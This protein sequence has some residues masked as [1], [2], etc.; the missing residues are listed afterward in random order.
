MEDR[1]HALIAIAFLVVFGVGAALI[2]LWMLSPGVVR[3]PYLLESKTSV[4]GL[5]P[6]SSVKFKGVLVGK[7]KTIHLDRRTH[8]S[9]E[10]MIAV[11]KNFPLPKGTY[12]TVSSNG[13]IG[14]E[15]VDLQLGPDSTTIQTSAAHPAH[16][17]LKAGG[18]S[19][20]MD[21][22]KQIV[23]DVQETLKSAQAVLSPQNRQQ[24][25]D[26]LGNLNKASA[27]LVQLEKTI[28]PSTKELPGLLAQA[29]ETLVTARDM[30]ANANTLVVKAQQP[31]DSLGQAASSTAAFTT[32]LSQETTPQLNALLVSL[33]TLVTRL[34]ALSAEL[35]QTPQS[36]ILGPAKPQPGP[37]E[38]PPRTQKNGG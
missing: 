9:I 21:Q 28:S 30:V 14:N 35:Q 36:L 1:S 38:T 4:G 16:L 7:V 17:Q 10:V 29:R 23:G 31:M 5:G 2:A 33:S 12:A 27:E 25:A 22:A 24:I 18:L 32:Q 15:F 34:D 26:T 19:A 3:V 6:G 20:M 11:D 8:R 13:F 37:G